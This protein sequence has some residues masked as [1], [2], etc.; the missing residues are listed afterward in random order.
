[1]SKTGKEILERKWCQKTANKM[2]DIHILEK[3]L[4]NRI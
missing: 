4:G 2:R 1:M 3:G